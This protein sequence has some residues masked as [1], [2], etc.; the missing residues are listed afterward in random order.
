VEKSPRVQQT[1]HASSF[2][3]EWP[4]QLFNLIL[5][6]HG[7]SF[8]EAFVPSRLECLLALPTDAVDLLPRTETSRI[9]ITEVSSCDISSHLSMSGHNSPMLELESP[10]VAAIISA[11]RESASDEK[12]DSVRTRF[13]DNFTT[14]R[15]H[16]NNIQSPRRSGPVWNMHRFNT[17]FKAH[18]NH[19]SEN[20]P[21]LK[22]SHLWSSGHIGRKSLRRYVCLRL[23]IITTCLS[24]RGPS[25]RSLRSHAISAH[26]DALVDAITSDAIITF[27]LLKN[28]QLDNDKHKFTSKDYIPELTRFS[29]SIFCIQ[30]DRPCLVHQFFMSRFAI[31][32]VSAG[33]S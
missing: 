20:E 18:K 10:H 4:P 28:K 1:I 19:S 21:A 9:C 29:S 8:N 12:M 3:A 30:N 25:R 32:S 13:F 33:K 17:S 11:P 16:I 7:M 5:D 2:L 14:G 23:G 31:R 22:H 15:V 6:V 26:L 24:N 27:G